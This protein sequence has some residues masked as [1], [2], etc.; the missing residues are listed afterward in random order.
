MPS[1]SLVGKRTRQL[2]VFAH[3]VLSLGWMGAGAAN[4]V[5]TSTAAVTGDVELRRA[6]YLLVREIDTWLVIPGAFGALVSGLVLSLVTPWGLAT[7]WWVLLK[8][9]LTVGVIVF[10]TFSVG[11]WVEESVLLGTA[12]S[13]VATALVVGPAASLASFLLMTWASVVKPWGR[14]PWSRRPVRAPRRNV[15]P[16]G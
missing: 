4:V 14:T 3:V 9:G 16:T 8:L 2:L 7:Y 1:R 6:C 13:P 11:V 5:L 12:E 15:V 10:S